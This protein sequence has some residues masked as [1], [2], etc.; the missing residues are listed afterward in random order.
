MNLPDILRQATTQT[1]KLQILDGDRMYKFII[2]L[3]LLSANQLVHAAG[4]SL[5][6]GTVFNQFA[7]QTGG[8]GNVSNIDDILRRLS[9]QINQTMPISV[10]QNT[11]LDKVSAEPGKQITFHY[12]ILGQ[13]AGVDPVLDFSKDVKPQL[14]EQLC[15]S[16]ETQKFLKNGVTVAYLYRDTSGR[17]MG[18]ATF[19]P[20]ECG[21]KS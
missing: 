6:V 14:K 17:E 10:D 11:R 21:Y 16:T 1:T 8:H 18:G 19:T 15:S 12:T 13:F 7:A 3:A 9:I 4:F 2:T 5:D 20:S